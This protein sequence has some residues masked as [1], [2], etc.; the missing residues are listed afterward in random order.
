[1]RL[2]DRFFHDP[3]GVA[4]ARPKLAVLFKYNQDQS[5]DDHGRWGSG[6]SWERTLAAVGASAAEDTHEGRALSSYLQDYTINDMLRTGELGPNT[7]YESD[8][9]K[10]V[11]RT[12][13]RMLA[14]RTTTEDA[15]VWRGYGSQNPGAHLNS[16]GLIRDRAFV[17]A[18]MDED[19]ARRF[20]QQE[21]YVA[22][23]EVPAGSH[24]LAVRHEA[25]ESPSSDVYSEDK[26]V[27]LPRG[28]AFE[29]VG[30]NHVTRTVS[31]RIKK[32]AADLAVKAWNPDQ[33]RDE[34]GRFSS[35]PKAAVPSREDQ[36]RSAAEIKNYVSMIASMY[37]GRQSSASLLRDHGREYHFD[38]DSF[39]GTK[40]T[41]GQCY[42]HAGRACLGDQD[43]TYVEGYVVLH[44]IPIEHA[45]TVDSSGLVHDP[46]LPDGK[47]ISG[48]Y[49]IPFSRQYVLHTSLET[50]VWGILDPVHNPGILSA[51][52]S[53]F[54][55]KF[56]A[57]SDQPR[58]YRGRWTSDPGQDRPPGR[59]DDPEAPR[60]TVPTRVPMSP[61]SYE[62][63]GRAVWSDE[64]NETAEEADVP[65]SALRAT[66][67]WVNPDYKL[68]DSVESDT[69]EGV[70]TPDGRINIFDGHHRANW[71]LRHGQPTI[72]MRVGYA[73]TV[74]SVT[75]LLVK[76]SEDQERDEH[77]RWTSGGGATHHRAGPVT[78]EEYLRHVPSPVTEERVRALAEKLDYPTD[79][80]VV[81][82]VA[83]KFELNGRTAEEAAHADSSTGI[84]TVVARDQTDRQLAGVM[85]HEIEHQKFESWRHD[86]AAN[87]LDIEKLAVSDGITPYSREYWDAFFNDMV[88]MGIRGALGTGK[89][90]TAVNETLAE[91]A[92]LNMNTTGAVH[93]IPAHVQIEP[94]WRRLYDA[95]EANW[96]RPGHFMPGSA[97][98]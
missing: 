41:L 57:K 76:F 21:S 90:V 92:R 45:W 6:G 40:K 87:D 11:V 52:S 34:R 53:E 72:R 8:E 82:Q 83:E 63:I 62:A 71:A 32:V 65:V 4:V 73:D 85:A 42:M 29:I 22:R 43:R 68:S 33:P 18:S 1:M 89:F 64:F 88:S 48:Y 81:S 17:S 30:V 60:G 69:P 79:K 54:L 14:E 3:R 61:Y 97:S 51:R 16:R 36:S 58:D 25:G 28:T 46:T 38:A 7:T 94:E 31:L 20:A 2:P 9:A 74:K 10:H 44:G 98:A 39:T 12:L 84:V 70:E 49:G 66:Q 67:D 93:S 78:T 47:G 77:G 24:M 91:M 56:L 59:V 26:E 19:V 5:R 80:V 35:G 96:Q 86:N 95:V 13:D 27:L 37:A 50:G 55:A 75:K 15:V 23:I